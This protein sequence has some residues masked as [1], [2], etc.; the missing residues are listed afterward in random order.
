MRTFGKWLGRALLALVLAAGALYLWKQDEI[1]RLM[2]VNS[3]F[4]EDRIV[5][6]FSNMD[7]AFLNVALSRGETA[8][9]PL[10]QG[11]ALEL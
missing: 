9:T 3:L 5:A 4:N 7:A 11:A 8:P 10:P 1:T 6:N 2:A